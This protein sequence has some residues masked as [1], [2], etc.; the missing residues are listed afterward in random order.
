MRKLSTI[1][2]LSTALFSVSA[3][4]ATAQSYPDQAMEWIVP[5]PAGG[6]TD[7]A[8]RQL[9]QIVEKDLGQ[10]IAILNVA[11]GG[12]VVG[13]TQLIQAQPDGHTLGAL[14][15]G[16]LTTV[17]NVQS[18]PYT[19]DDYRPIVSTSRTAYVICVKPDFPAETGEELLNELK[20]NP[21]KYTYGND[22]I[23]GTMQLAADRIFT[24]FDASAE[25]IPFGG[26]GET[27]QNFLGGHVDI[28]G[29][30][31]SPVLPYVNEG[32][33]KC[34]IATSEESI[35]ALPDAQSVADLGHPELAT[36]LWRAILAPKGLDDEKAQ[37]IADAVERAMENEDYLA[38]LEKQG[39]WP[40]VFR[41]EELQRQIQQEYDAL[42]QAAEA[43]GLK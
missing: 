10:S 35:P 21:E 32:E 28:Y 9:A 8:A 36:Y 17:P 41:G 11:G 18:V 29:G 7:T 5:A 1:A 33:A 34:L 13:M 38:F 25:P 15:N 20:E 39:E 3:A 26:A 23:G 12:G 24:A 27:L 43:L 4:V 31:I 19:L 22:G 40:A 16:P 30:S 37:V 2:L 14:W 42:G 6:G